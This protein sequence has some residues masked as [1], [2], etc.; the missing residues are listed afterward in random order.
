MN[1]TNRIV[2]A[3]VALSCVGVLSAQD[4]KNSSYAPVVPKEARSV[5]MARMRGLPNRGTATRQPGTT[6]PGGCGNEH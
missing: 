6:I 2:L 1:N 5:T 3:L 4:V